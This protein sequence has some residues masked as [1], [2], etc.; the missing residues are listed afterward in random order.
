MRSIFI[1]NVYMCSS[2]LSISTQFPS[3]HFKLLFLLNQSCN[4]NKQTNLIL[5]MNSGGTFCHS[6]GNKQTNKQT[7][8]I[9]IMYSWGTFCHSLGFLSWT[10][11]HAAA[12]KSEQGFW[13]VNMQHL[14]NSLL[15]SLNQNASSWKSNCIFFFFWYMIM[16]LP[17]IK[18]QFLRKHN[19]F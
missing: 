16:Q 1:S 19:S 7:N 6:L 8:L 10:D 18:T 2:L 3:L 17:T 14:I 12:D 15:A 11:H 4:F 5:R 9:L 13:Q